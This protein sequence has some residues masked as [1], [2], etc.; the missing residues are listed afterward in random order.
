[1]NKNRTPNQTLHEYAQSV[2]YLN[3]ELPYTY[4]NMFLL[5]KKYELS[6]LAYATVCDIFKENSSKKI[7]LIQTSLF[8]PSTLEQASCSKKRN[9]KSNKDSFFKEQK[10]QSLVKST[11][12]S[13]Y[14]GAWSKVIIS[15][16]KR[17]PTFPQKIA[18]IDLFAG[19]GRYEDGVQ[20]TPIKILKK[21]I[22]DNDLRDRLVTVFNDKDEKNSQELEKV[23]SE[24]PDI[25]KLRFYPNVWNK[26]VGVN[27]VQEFEKMNLIPTL[28]FVDPW[29]Y[30]G[31]SLR[32]INS[33]LKDWGCD[34]IFFFNYNRINMGLNNKLVEKHIN[35][36]FGDDRCDRLRQNLKD[37]N[38]SEREMLI[39][40]E[41]C[42]ALKEYGSRFVLPFRFKNT[43]GERTS[44]HLIFISKEFRGYE[45]MKDIM[46][47]ESSSKKEEV[48]SFE[49]NPGGSLPE[50]TLLFKLSSAYTLDR[51]KRELLE[52]YKG[53]R[54]KMI[55]IYNEHSIDTP[56][57]KKNYK[58]ALKE[59]LNENKIDA[60]SDKEKPP[61]K[62]T[63]GDSINVIFK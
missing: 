8:D 55:E 20:S 41:L 29:G 27:I 38:S 46:A 49:Y 54:I 14:F 4:D 58:T 36:L 5:K 19:P 50:Q 6:S 11:I 21:A 51:L 1:M 33:V 23:I 30:K 16:Q 25:D 10:E 57:T 2:F 34:A 15:T 7:K 62:G 28:F 59:L 40:E 52:R 53:R 56:F 9:K 12:V 39:I 42:K 63:F 26:E 13:K 22:I 37:L 3:K 48:A 60:I 47:S 18:Y 32:L 35:A 45:I 61:K 44:H 24:L 17:Y 31:L 43:K